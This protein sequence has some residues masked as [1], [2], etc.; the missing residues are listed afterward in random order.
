MLFELPVPSMIAADVFGWLFVHLA[1][2]QAITRMPERWFR[3]GS[4]LCRERAWEQGGRVYERLARI[5]DWKDRVP[6]GAAWLAGGFPK[7]ALANADDAYLMRFVVE[8]CRGEVAHWA[9][10]ACAGVFFLW[11]PPSVGVAMVAYGAAA[12]LPCIL[13]QRYN[14]VRLRRLLDA[15]ARR[16][17]RRGAQA[18]A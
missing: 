8:T 12:N 3:P 2:A 5:D 4:W 9:V 13:I 7:A 17:A 1:V 16:A 18:Q 11:N 15:R 14:R 10:F 6:D